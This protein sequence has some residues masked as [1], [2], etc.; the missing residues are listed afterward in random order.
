MKKALTRIWKSEDLRILSVISGCLVLS[1][2]FAATVYG[3][4][5]D[6]TPAPLPVS[7]TLSK[8]A[9]ST[10]PTAPPAIAPS[11]VSSSSTFVP[12][13]T[14]RTV[15][16]QTKY[17]NVTWLDKGQTQSFGGTDGWQQICST[18]NN[19]APSI[20]TIPPINK[21][22]WVGTR[23]PYKYTSPT[24]SPSPQPSQ[25][26]YSYSE[27]SNLARSNCQAQLGQYGA[28]DSSAMQQ[29][30]NAYMRQYGY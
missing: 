24:P 28:A 5:R 16:Y 6:K 14:K 8:Q 10:S 1:W 30:Y 2:L 18:P 4:S 17:E 23:E 11:N 9:L 3:I 26:R 27:A 29:C 13:C 15:P 21:T 25:P 12:K 20:V 22:V 19:G 7:Q